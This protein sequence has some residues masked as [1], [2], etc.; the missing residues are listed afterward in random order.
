[1]TTIPMPTGEDRASDSQRANDSQ[2]IRFDV[3]R[4]M[5][6]LCDV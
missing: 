5:K 6:G 2:A 1:V 3:H 4:N